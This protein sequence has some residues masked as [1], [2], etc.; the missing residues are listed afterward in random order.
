MR[1]TTGEAAKWIGARSPARTP[2]RR[3]YSSAAGSPLI[4]FTTR[5]DG[6]ASVTTSRSS[7]GTK[8][9]V[10]NVFTRRRVE[11]SARTAPAL[12]RDAVELIQQVAG[13]GLAVTD[14][15]LLQPFDGTG[16]GCACAG[17]EAHAREA[18]V[19]AAGGPD[20]PGR[21]AADHRDAGE[22]ACHLGG[23]RVAVVGARA[24]EDH[25]RHARLRDAGEELLH[26]V[27]R[28]CRARLRGADAVLAAHGAFS[29]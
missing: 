13:D 1:T 8:C 2:R 24:E 25:E 19:A 23:Q 7:V 15:E 18:P 16:D 26:G 29:R 20:L 21:R 12:R 17:G 14:L 6:S 5:C 27:A 28:I 9:C 4:S 22:A 11:I 3:A 10:L